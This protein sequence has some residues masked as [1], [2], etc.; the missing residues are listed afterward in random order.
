MLFVNRVLRKI[1][2]LGK[3]KMT[4][5]LRKL[6]KKEHSSWGNNRAIKRRKIRW[7]GYVGFM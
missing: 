7:E 4:G 1:L 5:C 6:H 2:D 3:K